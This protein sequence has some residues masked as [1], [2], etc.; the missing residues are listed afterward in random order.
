MKNTVILVVEPGKAAKRK[1]DVASLMEIAFKRRCFEVFAKHFRVL[2]IDTTK[3]N[4]LDT[5]KELVKHVD[6]YIHS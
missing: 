2:V 5:F 4:I 3:I 6:P 1:S